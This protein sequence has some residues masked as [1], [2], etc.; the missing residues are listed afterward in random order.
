MPIVL[1]LPGVVNALRWSTVPLLANTMGPL[2]Q[3][4]QRR[5][6]LTAGHGYTPAGTETADPGDHPTGTRL[7]QRSEQ[8]IGAPSRALRHKREAIQIRQ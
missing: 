5:W 7:P 2:S 8:A 4:V 3:A 6:D 1:P